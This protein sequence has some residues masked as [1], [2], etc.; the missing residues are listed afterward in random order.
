MDKRYLSIK[1]LSQYSGIAVKT[2]YNWVSQRKIPVC[3]VNG[4]M[5][6]FD[7]YEIDKLMENNKVP[8]YN[9]GK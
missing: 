3:K 8:A 4:K 2:I 9:T 7:K 6:R 1:D 5:L